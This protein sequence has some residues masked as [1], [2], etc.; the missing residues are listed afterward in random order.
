MRATV[1]DM[2][3][4]SYITAGGPGDP[5]RKATAELG[6]ESNGDKLFVLVMESALRHKDE[7]RCRGTENEFPEGVGMEM[8]R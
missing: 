7:S 3:S 4:R 8:T 2:Y 6:R 1:S 5:R